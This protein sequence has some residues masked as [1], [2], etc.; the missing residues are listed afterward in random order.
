MENDE[1]S[2]YPPGTLIILTDAGRQ[3][4][5]LNRDTVT[6]VICKS[7]ELFTVN[8]YWVH[9]MTSNGERFNL[10]TDEFKILQLP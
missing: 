9:V 5:S 6:G 4:A 10:F 1:E 3:K 7:R 2:P 8:V